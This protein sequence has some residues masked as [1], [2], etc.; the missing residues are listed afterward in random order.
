MYAWWWQLYVVTLVSRRNETSP[1]QDRDNRC[2]YN[3][4]GNT[5]GFP[6]LCSLRYARHGLRSSKAFFPSLV[7]LSVFDFEKQCNGKGCGEALA[8]VQVAADQLQEPSPL[9][10]TRRRHGGDEDSRLGGERGTLA[11]KQLQILVS[12]SP[13][14]SVQPSL[15]ASTSAEYREMVISALEANQGRRCSWHQRPGITEYRRIR[16]YVLGNALAAKVWG[17]AHG[18]NAISDQ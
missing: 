1:L 5:Q 14:S 9:V 3:A 15:L 17:K 4:D 7:P 2:Y 16:H 12:P 18:V 13:D 11:A 6:F 10:Y 8:L